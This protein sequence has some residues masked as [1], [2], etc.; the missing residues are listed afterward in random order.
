MP[1]N[2]AEAAGLLDDYLGLTAIESRR[3]QTDRRRGGLLDAC[4]ATARLGENG[5]RPIRLVCASV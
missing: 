1:V 4:L 2:E 5:E 3:R